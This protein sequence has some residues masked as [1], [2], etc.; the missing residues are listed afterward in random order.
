[1]IHDAIVPV[2]CD[3]EKCLYHKNES[4][5]IP[6][7]FPAGMELN[8]TDHGWRVINGKHYC[9]QACADEAEDGKG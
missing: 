2:T 8:L 1:M 5:Y 9:S 4:D 6:F 3:N 7:S